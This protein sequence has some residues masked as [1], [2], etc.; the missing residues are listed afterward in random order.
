MF[1][2]IRF[3]WGTHRPSLTALAVKSRNMV[4]LGEPVVSYILFML[5]GNCLY[6]DMVLLVFVLTIFIPI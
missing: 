3:I 6:F 4:T 2:R 5:I 1:I